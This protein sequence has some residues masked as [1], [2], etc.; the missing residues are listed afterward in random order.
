MGLVVHFFQLLWRATRPHLLR[1]RHG[2]LYV[3][4]HP[5]LSWTVSDWHNEDA[6]VRLDFQRRL[7]VATPGGALLNLDLQGFLEM[8]HLGGPDATDR[9]RVDFTGLDVSVDLQIDRAPPYSVNS[10]LTESGVDAG[11]V[12]GD[13]VGGLVFLWNDPS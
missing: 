10:R 3:F 12:T 1:R 8:G 5:V 13:I 6:E 2:V 11:V 4:T 9:V 7:S